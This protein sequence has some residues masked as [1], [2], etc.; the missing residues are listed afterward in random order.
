MS[1]ERVFCAVGDHPHG[2]LWDIRSKMPFASLTGHL[3]DCFSVAINSDT[4]QV[5]TGSQ[6]LT[7]RIY[8]LRKYQ[9]T[10]HIL[11]PS[12][13]GGPV[14]NLTYS[15]DGNYLAAVEADDYVSIVEVK[16]S[17]YQFKQSIDVFGRLHIMGSSIFLMLVLLGELNGI[18]FSKD[19]SS[20]CFGASSIDTGGLLEYTKNPKAVP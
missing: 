14:R 2:Q 4:Y 15:P 7:V 13:L 12:E 17:D 11:P 20:L 19:S 18:T 3:D 5:A 10:L 16:D 8:D 1:D 9:K 6:D